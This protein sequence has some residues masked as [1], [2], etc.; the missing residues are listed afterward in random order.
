MVVEEIV[1]LFVTDTLLV[2]CNK[3][4]GLKEYMQKK[5]SWSNK[6]YTDNLSV[7]IDN[8]YKLKLQSTNG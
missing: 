2:S 6:E 1:K 7:Y 3:S 4:G 8:I 5:Y